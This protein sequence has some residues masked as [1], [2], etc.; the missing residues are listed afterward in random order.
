MLS[1]RYSDLR[2]SALVIDPKSPDTIYA[3]TGDR[4][5]LANDGI[6]KSTDGGKTWKSISAGLPLNPSGRHYSILTI[7]IDPNDSQTIY[8]GGFGG[9]YRS[10]DGGNSWERL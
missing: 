2:I 8:A 5:N 7:A 3:G 4:A 1:P 6:Y 9:L 10:T